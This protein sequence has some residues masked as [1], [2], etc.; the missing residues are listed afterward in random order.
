MER[1]HEK[2]KVIY[3]PQVENL[4]KKEQIMLEIFSSWQ[5]LPK[6]QQQLYWV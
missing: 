4:R 1:K 3:V 6:L 5:G 2:Q